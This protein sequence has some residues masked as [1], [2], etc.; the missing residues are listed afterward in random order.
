M[1]F[2]TFGFYLQFATI[3][4]GIMDLFLTQNTESA[5]CFSIYAIQSLY[6][7]LFGLAHKL[8]FGLVHPPVQ[9]YCVTESLQLDERPV[10]RVFAMFIMW[11]QFL[12]I[13][14]TF[15]L[16]GKSH[17]WTRITEYFGFLR[18]WVLFLVLCN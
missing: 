10:L 1:V 15:K 11:S 14:F 9:S 12:G 17:K 18:I 5:A 7:K 6:Y 13:Q 16:N 2:D 3:L 8:E 4:C